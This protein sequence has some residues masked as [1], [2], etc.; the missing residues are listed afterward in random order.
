MKKEDIIKAAQERAKE[1]FTQ[2]YFVHV[3]DSWYYDE[4]FEFENKFGR[5]TH[6]EKNI[7]IDEMARLFDEYE[8]R[9]YAEV[10]AQVAYGDCIDC[11]DKLLRVI[12]KSQRYSKFEVDE[13]T[14]QSIKDIGN[15]FVNKH[16]EF[17]KK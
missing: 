14:I 8:D 12:D 15:I 9:Y 7:Y 10:N 3:T 16:N 2:E 5:V 13:K 4:M 1:I 17:C 6:K 11:I